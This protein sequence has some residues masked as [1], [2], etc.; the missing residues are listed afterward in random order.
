MNFEPTVTLGALLQA[1]AFLVCFVVMITKISGRIDL[2][3]LRLTAVEE[4]LKN[5][6][7][8]NERI[9]VIEARQTTDQRLVSTLHTDL[10]D[11]RHGRGFIKKD[12]SGG[13]DGEYS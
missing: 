8:F 6:R 4:T 1:G 9:A 5:T 12:R 13:T 10:S 3:A 7:D 2:L 11:L